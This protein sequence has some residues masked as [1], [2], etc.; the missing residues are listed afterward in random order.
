MGEKCDLVQAFLDASLR[1]LGE[2]VA[3]SDEKEE[4]SREKRFLRCRA[5]LCERADALKVLGSVASYLENSHFL[6]DK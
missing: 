6:T 3:G 1:Y 4:W 2:P 5:I